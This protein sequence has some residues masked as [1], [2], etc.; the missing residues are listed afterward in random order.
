M[1]LFADIL[2]IERLYNH[3]NWNFVLSLEELPSKLKG[4]VRNVKKVEAEIVALKISYLKKI[5]KGTN[6]VIMDTWVPFKACAQSFHD[7]LLN[8]F[9]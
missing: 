7:A 8:G 4:L 3:Q 9:F 1:C 6:I 5:N 2:L